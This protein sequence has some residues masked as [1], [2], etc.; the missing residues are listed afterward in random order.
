MF[1]VLNKKR[2]IAVVLIIVL[3]II[4][5]GIGIGINETSAQN[6]PVPIY[7]VDCNENKVALTF[8]CAWGADKTR[9]IMDL[10]EGA[11]YKCTFF[12]T[13]FWLDANQELVKEIH[14]RGHQIANHSENHPHLSK[15]DKE[16]L[17]KEINSVNDKIKALTGENVTCFRAPFGEYDN[18]LLETLNS[19][20]MLCI[21]WS[22][23]SLDWKGIS[24]KEITER[25]ANRLKSGDI[26]LFHN[27]SDHILEAL[28]LILASVKN[29]DLESVRVDELV[30]FENYKIDAEGKQ[31]KK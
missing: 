11:G 22:I 12:I 21:Q 8:D 1:L 30:Y 25:V 28:P 13:G 5:A 31:I 29:K 23:D 20:N 10:I 6:R 18:R 27:N 14:T 4:G 15:V 9:G 26:V 19:K 17:E 2:V 16:T 7:S 24:G 3:L